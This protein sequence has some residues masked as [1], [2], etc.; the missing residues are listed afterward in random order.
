MTK[1]EFLMLAHNYDIKKHGIAGW[2][3]SEKLDGQRCFWDGGLTRNMLKANVPWANTDK[4]DR[5]K[6]TQYCTGLWSRYG[7]V[8]HAPGW[9]LDEL[10]NM[11]LDGELYMGRHSRQELM[12]AIRPLIPI[13][14]LW[15]GVKY[16]VFD[17]P[18][19]GGFLQ[20]G[21]INNPNFREKIMNKGMWQW[22]RELAKESSFS[23][24]WH[25][26]LTDP[27]QFRSV[28]TMLDRLVINNHVMQRV[29]QHQLPF[30][31][32]TAQE[33]SQK[34][35]EGITEN[36]GEGVML[37]SPDQAW[38]PKRVHGLVKM[39]KLQDA[40]AM[41]LGY[42]SGRQTDRGSKLLGLMGALIV[43]Y[44]GKQ[45]ELS[46]FT[47]EER[48]LLDYTG[49]CTSNPGS[50]VPE[51]ILSDHFPRGSLVTFRYRELSKDGIPIEARYWRK[52]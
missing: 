6:A 47:D 38:E 14:G 18:S 37:R 50:T 34:M 24:K 29:V 52:A 7:N 36:G 2:Y 15:D 4:D 25:Y 39:K 33:V 9:W 12:S 45:F 8:I 1:R 11:L 3:L 5:L 27:M 42:V 35:L 20:T 19:W 17:M 41:V 13:D 10:P 30:S 16:H 28:V 48:G 40:E 43:E 23:I 22:V 21:R 51:T 32:F 26:Y 44:Q 46:G 49:W 31:T